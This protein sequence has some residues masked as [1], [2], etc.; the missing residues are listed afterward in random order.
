MESQQNLNNIPE[1][2]FTRVKNGD[3]S[4][5]PNQNS[6]LE[7]DL[8]AI[9]EVTLDNS[10]DIKN[11]NPEIEVFNHN[12]ENNN[13]ICDS[14]SEENSDNKNSIKVSQIQKKENGSTIK[15]FA[16]EFINL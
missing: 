7:N 3:I 5:N 8:G 10:S 11:N 12:E 2:T 14:S 4:N 6:I 1:Y 15:D 16:K 13:Y 9:E